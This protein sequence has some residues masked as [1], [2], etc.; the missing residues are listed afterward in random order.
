V[1]A[2]FLI[3]NLIKRQIQGLYCMPMEGNKENDYYC[4]Q[5]E[6]GSSVILFVY[7]YKG[8]IKSKTYLMMDRIYKVEND[9]AMP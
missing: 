9:V 6:K 4:S 1:G 5:G 8:Y 3:L 2:P 7:T